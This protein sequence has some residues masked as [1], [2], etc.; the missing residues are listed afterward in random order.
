[1]KKYAAAILAVGMLL[2]TACSEVPTIEAQ[3]STET[4]SVSQTEPEKE[5]EV[6]IQPETPVE[7]PAVS[8]SSESK[9]ET[10]SKS[11]AE[12]ADPNQSA[13]PE[14]ALPQSDPGKE[15]SISI[16]ITFEIVDE[17][18]VPEQ[19]N[20]VQ[21]SAPVETPDPETEPEESDTEEPAEPSVAEPTP[22]PE[23]EPEPEPDPTPEPEPEPAF[24][25]SYWVSFAKSYGQ[26]VGLSY[27]P[28]A[29][30]CWDN[31]IIASSKS[32]YLERD[33]TSRLSRYVREGMTAF[34]VWSEPLADGRYNI[35]I[36]YA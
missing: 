36:G 20:P 12:N 18:K 17:E 6:G 11:A 32:I 29:T 25:V 4:A 3:V 35:Y 19:E 21:P 1:M 23:P 30:S 26:Q 13:I 10:A 9:V 5:P 27:D 33:I 28:Q 15:Q 34:C 8:D 24:D 22:E 2:L 16:P 31:P 14:T 7:N